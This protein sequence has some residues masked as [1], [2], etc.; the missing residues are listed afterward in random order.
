M[1]RY[2]ASSRPAFGRIQPLAGSCRKPFALARSLSRGTTVMLLGRALRATWPEG[3]KLLRHCR[4]ARFRAGAFAPA[5]SKA[6]WRSRRGFGTRLELRK[7]VATL[8]Q[9]GPVL[10]Y[11][12]ARSLSPLAGDRCRRSRRGGRGALAELVFVLRAWSGGD[13]IQ[14]LAYSTTVRWMYP[15]KSFESHLELERSDRTASM[16]PGR[17]CGPHGQRRGGSRPQRP[18]LAPAPPVLARCALR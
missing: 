10:V 15:R 18:H 6:R 4:T 12:K 16:A 13:P 2:A 17:L 3:G 9:T 8:E 5:P 14:S 1:G 11:I 7:L